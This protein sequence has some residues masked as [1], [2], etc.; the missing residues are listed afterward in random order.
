VKV[1]NLDG[2]SVLQGRLQMFYDW[3]D[4]DLWA[5]H[6]KRQEVKG[7]CAAFPVEGPFKLETI[8]T[9]DAVVDPFGTP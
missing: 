9:V 7:F 3:F 2:Q 8:F 5:V 1:D 4:L 6:A